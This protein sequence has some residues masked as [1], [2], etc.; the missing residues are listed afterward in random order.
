MEETMSGR[1][2]TNSERA[3]KVG[4]AVLFE[5]K[6]IAGCF[7]LFTTPREVLRS[8]LKA[9]AYLIEAVTGKELDAAEIEKRREELLKKTTPF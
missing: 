7:N 6:S 2:L 3:V 1:S 5:A 9:G 4:L 8:D